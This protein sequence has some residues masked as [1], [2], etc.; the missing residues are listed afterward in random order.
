MDPVLERIFV[1]VPESMTEVDITD[2]FSVGSLIVHIYHYN[3][4]NLVFKL[5]TYY[6]N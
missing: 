1:K 4:F 6:Y 5:Y 3:E 2:Q